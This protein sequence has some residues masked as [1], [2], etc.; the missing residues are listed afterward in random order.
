[1]VLKVIITAATGM[2]GKGVLYE[3]L[4]HPEIERVLCINRQTLGLSHSKLK[5][6]IHP[7][8]FNW[9]AIRESLH[10]YDACFFCLGVTS[11]M[12]WIP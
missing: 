5:E 7:D 1:M 11:Q 2:V 8:F 4:D 3:C 6:I 10:G 12:D 9:T